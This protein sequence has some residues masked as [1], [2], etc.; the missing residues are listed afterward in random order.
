MLKCKDICGN[1][2]TKECKIPKSHPIDC[3]RG[4]LKDSFMYC[5]MRQEQTGL[6]LS[7]VTYELVVDKHIKEGKSDYK[8]TEK[9]ETEM[10]LQDFLS[11]FIKDFPK[12]SQ[13]TLEAWYLNAVKNA[14]FSKAYQPSFVLHCVS[15]FA[16]NIQIE[17]KDEVSEEYFHKKQIA[18][19]GTMTSITK[20][21][22]VPDGEGSHNE[23]FKHKL[24]QITSSNN[25]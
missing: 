1:K 23:K 24:S 6:Y 3:Q 12:F 7:Y 22:R 15:D 10:S 5:P 17:K 18:L 9:I 4:L 8:K 2:C 14:A 16:Q 25:K 13:H 11:A 20:T 21:A 19:F